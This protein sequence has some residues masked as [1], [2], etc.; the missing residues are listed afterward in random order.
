MLELN[1]TL[2]EQSQANGA[3]AQIGNLG[4]TLGAPVMAFAL[5]GWGY[6]SLP[7]LAGFAF[8]MGL[9]FHL[10]LEKYRRNA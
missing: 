1:S 3:M 6:P 5:M 7:V 9:I 4:N 2:T 10:I 8:V